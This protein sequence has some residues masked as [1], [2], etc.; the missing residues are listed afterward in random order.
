M[1]VPI[2][3]DSGRVALRSR[4]IAA[5]SMR[6]GSDRGRTSDKFISVTV[7]GFQLVLFL[8]YLHTIS[9]Y[10]NMSKSFYRF[11]LCYNS[12]F[13]QSKQSA[14]TNKVHSQLVQIIETTV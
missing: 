1:V 12:Y 2:G 10:Y 8:L 3:S 11:Q 14:N 6:R 5:W 7:L 9:H 4:S 13:S